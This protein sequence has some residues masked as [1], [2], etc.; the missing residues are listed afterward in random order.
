MM[1]NVVSLIEWTLGSLKT[2][3]QEE[4]SGYLGFL[5]DLNIGAINKNNWNL[6]NTIPHKNCMG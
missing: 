1:E 3:W 2:P 5:E 6:L 4:K